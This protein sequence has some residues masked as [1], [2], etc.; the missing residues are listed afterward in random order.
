MQW[1]AIQLEINCFEREKQMTAIGST[2]IR[3]AYVLRLQSCDK[4]FNL[5][6]QFMYL[7]MERACFEI[8]LLFNL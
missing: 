1:N 5:V 8:I 4:S 6:T 7:S 2:K 3:Q